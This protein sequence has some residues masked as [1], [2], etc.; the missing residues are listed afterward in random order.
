VRLH[1]QSNR[2]DTRSSGIQATTFSRQATK[3]W[4]DADLP[5]DGQILAFDLIVGATIWTELIVRWCK[6][7]RSISLKGPSRRLV[8]ELGA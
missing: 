2:S 5:G 4:S 3:S 1:R 7:A 8:A 6:I